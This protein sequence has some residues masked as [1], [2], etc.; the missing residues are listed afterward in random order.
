MSG[1]DQFAVAGGAGHVGHVVFVRP[2]DMGLGDVALAVRA[3]GQQLFRRAGDEDQAARE[4]GRGGDFAVQPF[5]APQ[6]AAIRRRR[7]R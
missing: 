2:G 3:D 1:E 6:F 5:D 7:R 4:D